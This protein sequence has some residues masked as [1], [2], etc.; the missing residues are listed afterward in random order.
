M[1]QP[2]EAARGRGLGSP[3]PS[4]LPMPS[5]TTEGAQG[6][7]RKQDPSLVTTG[8]AGHTL[9]HW[10]HLPLFRITS[11]SPRLFHGDRGVTKNSRA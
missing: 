10:P 1:Q 9:L 8:K 5:P 11:R 6:P 3:K 2:D 4:H 7:S